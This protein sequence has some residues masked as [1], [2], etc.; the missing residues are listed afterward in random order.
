MAVKWSCKDFTGRP[1]I[2]RDGDLE[3]FEGDLVGAS[4]LT[5]HQLRQVAV[6]SFAND[7]TVRQAYADP[8]RMR[9]STLL[10]IGQ[11]A[12]AL[13]LAEPRPAN[14]DPQTPLVA[15]SRVPP[16]SSGPRLR[17]GKN[18]GR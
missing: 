4:M 12:R 13:G 18:R 7:R 11:A 6:A 5:H 15:L 16:K 3:F 2:L 9:E 1:Q 10:R 14:P 17:G 8:S